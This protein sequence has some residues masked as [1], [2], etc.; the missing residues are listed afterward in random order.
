MHCANCGMAYYAHGADSL[1]CFDGKG[2]Y[3]APD[4]EIEQEDDGRW[5][6]E[7]L[8]TP[9]AM[10][11]GKTPQ[12]ALNNASKIA[13][14]ASE[15]I[16]TGDPEESREWTLTI[17]RLGGEECAV[18]REPGKM[19]TTTPILTRQLPW[20]NALKNLLGRKMGAP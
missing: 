6:A 4:I 12:E 5:I 11:Y 16:K 2:M 18:L 17:E 8:A 3:S 10:A 1:S 19:D 9:G 13:Q 15:R 14:D 20:F 7:I